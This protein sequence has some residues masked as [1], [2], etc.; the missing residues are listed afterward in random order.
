MRS[1][2]VF[3]EGMKHA[4]NSRNLTS[5]CRDNVGRIVPYVAVRYAPATYVDGCHQP[6]HPNYVCEDA[7]W[8]SRFVIVVDE[9]YVPTVGKVSRFTAI[10]NAKVWMDSMVNDNNEINWGMSGVYD[11]PAMFSEEISSKLIKVID[12]KAKKNII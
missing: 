4:R 12:H 11:L 9:S 10:P 5:V 3:K 6:R 8:Q 7:Y 2:K 1:V